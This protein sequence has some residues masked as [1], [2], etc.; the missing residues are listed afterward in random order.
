[1][2]KLSDYLTQEGKYCLELYK[3]K[4]RLSYATT[5]D[6]LIEYATKIKQGID[7]IIG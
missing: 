6:E 3:R 2:A 1:M 7:N 5:Q 4:E